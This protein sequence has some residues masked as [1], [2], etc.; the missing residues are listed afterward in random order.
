[1]KKQNA[2]DILRLSLS[3]LVGLSNI[4]YCPTYTVSPK[5]LV[6]SHLWSMNHR[7]ALDL[8]RTSIPY[9]LHRQGKWSCVFE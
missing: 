7:R 2:C 5:L 8:P 1:M 4:A 3:L 9:S 6:S